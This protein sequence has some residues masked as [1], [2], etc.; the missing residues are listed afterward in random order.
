MPA[1]MDAIRKNPFWVLLAGQSV[2]LLGTGMTRFAVLIW[3]YQQEG[4]ATAS[5]LLG[6]FS[7]ITFVIA[8]PFAGVLVDRW[9]R[10]RLMAFAD[11]GAGYMTALLLA[12]YAT[13]QLHVWHLY[14]AQGVAGAMEAF[15][16]PAFSASVSLLIPREGYT[17]AHGLLGLGKSAARIFAPALAGLLM[18][19]GDLTWVMAAD[20]ST[21]SLAL[22]GLLC[23]RIPA[24]PR[25]VEGRSAAGGFSRQMR[26]GFQYIVR[27]PGLRH[28]LLTFF[29]VNLFGTVTYFAVLSPMIL[30]RTGGDEFGLGVVRTMMGVGG[31]VGGVLVSLWGRRARRKTRIYLLSTL[32]SFLICDFLTAIS[33]SV[34]GWSIAGFLSELSIPFIVSPY[35]ALWQEIVPLDVQGRVFSTREMIQVLSQPVGYLAGGLLADRLFEPAMQAGGALVGALGWLVG[36]GPGA[37]MAAMFLCTS[38]GGALTGLLGWLSPAI[39]RLDTT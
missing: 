10:R 28:L 38:L 19:T 23:I 25:S 26:F 39:R 1:E 13:G 5:A 8:S 37:G 35:F 14:L 27:R 31:V 36:T 15:Q 16:D 7:C 20:L 9:D 21:L 18:A 11:L 6:F 33:R 12:L 32:L 17:R 2:S 29:L 22:L 24:P 4:T 3:A 30:A 34:T